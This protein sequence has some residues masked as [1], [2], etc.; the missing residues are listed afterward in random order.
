MIAVS[1]GG[2]QKNCWR[3]HLTCPIQ[4][5]TFNIIISGFAADLNIF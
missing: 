3:F 4:H 5:S 2:Y 1:E